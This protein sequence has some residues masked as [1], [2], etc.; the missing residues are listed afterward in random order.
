MGDGRLQKNWRSFWQGAADE[1]WE[2]VSMGMRDAATP[3]ASSDNTYQATAIY[4]HLL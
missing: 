2:D 1:G 4:R 3:Q